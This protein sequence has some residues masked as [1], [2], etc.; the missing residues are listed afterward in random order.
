M[1]LHRYVIWEWK[2]QLLAWDVQQEDGTSAFTIYS[3]AKEMNDIKSLGRKG[4]QCEE[5]PTWS[6]PNFDLLGC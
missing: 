4:I 2:I 1:S 5:T 3:W 6:L